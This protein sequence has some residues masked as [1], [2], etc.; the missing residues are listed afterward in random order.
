MDEDN[1]LTIEAYEH[2]LEKYNAAAI[3]EVIGSVKHWVDISLSL[4]PQGARILE[5]GSAHGRDAAYIEAKGFEVRRTD[6]ASSFVKYMRKQGHD[7][8][9]LN[10]LS[11]QYGGPYEMV[12]ANA[13]LLH[14]TAEQTKIV[15]Q[16]AYET[17]APRGLFSF[18]V[19]IGDGEAWSEAK[20]NSPRYF[21]YWREQALKELIESSSFE[22]VLWEEGHTG[23]DN[24]DWYHVI[25]LRSSE[26]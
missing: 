3:P 10:A 24:G 7:A 16:K 17:L 23:H 18:S 6:A 22:I 4:L 1:S 14:F 19:K 25:M 26:S 5:L 11:D 9:I 2:S 13:V 21:A 20:L 15:F 12:Y 8:H